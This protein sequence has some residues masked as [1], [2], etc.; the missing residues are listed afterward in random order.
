MQQDKFIYL[1]DSFNAI[2]EE[3]EADPTNY[4]EA[5][6]SEDVIVWLGIMEVKLESMCSNKV[7]DLTETSKWIKPIGCKW[8]Y[9]RKMGVDEKVETYKVRLA[10]KAYG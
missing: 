3:H 7:F 9:K 5:M 6:S 1:G 10:M 8:V 4:D 2:L